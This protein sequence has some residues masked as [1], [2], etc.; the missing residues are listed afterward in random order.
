MRWK[1]L[2][3][4]QKGISSMEGGGGRQR[5]TRVV[6]SSQHPLSALHQKFICVPYMSWAILPVPF[7]F[8]FLLAIHVHSCSGRQSVSLF[9][10][11]SQNLPNALAFGVQGNGSVVV[12]DSHAHGPRCAAL[13]A[14]RTMSVTS[15]CT[16]QYLACYFKVPFCLEPDTSASL[17]SVGTKEVPFGLQALS[18]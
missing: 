11:G 4:V 17:W 16:T 9:G 3:S 7:S 14:V 12:P 5:L 13:L 1:C 15:T 2:L 18:R 8:F 6:A 10:T